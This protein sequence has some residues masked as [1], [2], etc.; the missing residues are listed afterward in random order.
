M[1]CLGTRPEAIKLAP[2]IQ[3]AQKTGLETCI[4]VSGQHKELLA[5]FLEFFQLRVNY[6]LEVLKPNQS[7]SELTA[8]ILSKIQ[9][10]LQ[11][12]KPDLLFVQG[13]TTTTFTSA[14][15]AFYEKIPVAHIE[16]GLRTHDRYSPFPEEM[17]R[18]LVSSIAEYFFAPTELS[19][20]NLVAEGI[21]RNVWVTGNTGIDALRLTADILKKSTASAVSKRTGK[22]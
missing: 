3:A 21:T 20:Q 13:D 16:A 9:P 5:P 11:K 19:K 22:K 2:L 6:N 10:I 18:K 1:F 7:L 14:L 4:V 8:S 17:N 15:A 12:E